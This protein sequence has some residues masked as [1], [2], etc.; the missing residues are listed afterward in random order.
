PGK[1]PGGRGGQR[2]AAVDP[3]LVG[4][5]W[6]RWPAA[7]LALVTGRCFDVLDLDGTQGMEA[8][9]A[10]LSITPAGHPG[11]VARPGGGGWHLLYRSTGLGNRVGLLP[12]VDWRGRGG[13]IVASPSRPSSRRRYSWVRPPTPTL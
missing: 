2:L 6:R 1:H 5:W 11:P 10:T 9:G 13:L 7:N 3:A 4:E 8:L 12:G